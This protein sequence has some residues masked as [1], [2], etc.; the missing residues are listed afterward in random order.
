MK[1]LQF[2]STSKAL[3][4]ANKSNFEFEWNLAADSNA[5]VDASDILQS[6]QAKL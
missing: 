4:V 5:G 1:L 6:N 2:T 3:A